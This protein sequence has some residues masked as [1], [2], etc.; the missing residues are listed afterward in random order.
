MEGGVGGVGL[1]REEG[2]VFGM[3]GMRG[4]HGARR[5]SSAKATGSHVS[6]AAPSW[7]MLKAPV[8][9]LHRQG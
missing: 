5:M 2:A 8:F 9:L 7:V 6:V 3:R 1:G 4:A